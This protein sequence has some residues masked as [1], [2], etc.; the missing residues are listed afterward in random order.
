ME[1]INFQRLDNLILNM[2]V[3]DIQLCGDYMMV[4]LEILLVGMRRLE[5]GSKQ[6]Q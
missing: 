4:D 1:T 5:V 6:D 3:V 2:I